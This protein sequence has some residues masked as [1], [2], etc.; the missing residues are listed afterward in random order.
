MTA[1]GDND[2]PARKITVFGRDFTMPRSR[3]LRVAIGIALILGGILGFLPI[4]GFWMVPIGLLVLSYEFALVRRHRR[5]LVV[6]W[7]RRRRPNGS[8]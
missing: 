4:L 8:D 1:A 5:R 2:A 6:W 3:G 7:Q